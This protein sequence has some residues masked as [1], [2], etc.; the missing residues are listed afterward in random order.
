MRE[1]FDDSLN[2]CLEDGM[3]LAEESLKGSSP[4]LILPNDAFLATPSISSSER[5]GGGNS[6]AVLPFANVSNDPENEYF[7]DGLAEEL[8]NMLAKIDDL[9]VVARTS[10]FSFK[11]K[12]LDIATIGAVLNVKWILEGSV[13]RSGTKLRIT[14]QLI[15]VEDGYRQWSERYDREM[16]DIFGIQDD[17][18]L[19]VVEELKPRLLGGEKTAALKHF[20]FNKDA[21]ERYL[22]GRFFL[23]KFTPENFFKAI[24]LFNSALQA[25]DSYASAFAGL[26][27]AYVMLTEMGPLEPR[28]GMPKARSMA[29]KALELDDTL[30]EAHCSLGLILQDYEYDHRSAAVR[31]ERAMKLSPGNPS[32]HQ[33]YGHLLAQLGDHTAA[34]SQFKQALAVDPLSV[35]GNWI[36][37]HGLFEARRYDESIVQARRSLELDPNFPAAFLTLAFSYQMSGDYEASVG[38]YARFSGSLGNSHI[39]ALIKQSYEE[40]GWEGFLRAMTDESRPAELSWY[41]VA[42]FDAALG[43]KAKAI[44]HLERSYEARE[45]YLVI[46][47]VDPRMDVLRDEC[48]FK[49]LVERVGFAA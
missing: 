11:D 33:L 8:L 45:P 26:A 48:G 46:L 20:A 15:K 9:R 28:E 12:G 2:Y 41:I 5:T 38:E 29:E 44:A 40:K 43:E 42:A 6:I 22:R 7:C 4:T 37:G 17:I 19:A 16:S 18:A 1:Y 36:Y 10:A 34:E 13:R 25:D 23:N 21:Y 49:A 47:N 39:A 30:A 27:D 32:A 14:V 35:I 31:Y 3:R 24:E